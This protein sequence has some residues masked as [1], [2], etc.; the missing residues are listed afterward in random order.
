MKII[1]SKEIREL[2]EIAGLSIPE[3]SLERLASSVSAVLHYMDEIRSLEI[4]SLPET[5]RHSGEVN[6]WREDVVGDS[7]AH[8]ELFSNGKSKDGYFVVPAIITH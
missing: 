8:L 1:T 5:V 2:A 7:L 4:G 6:V 3:A